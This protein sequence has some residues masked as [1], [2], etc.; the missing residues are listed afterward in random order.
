[1]QFNTQYNA[2]TDFSMLQKL[3]QLTISL[4]AESSLE[5][6]YWVWRSY[7]CAMAT[8]FIGGETQ[9]NTMQ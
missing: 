9:Y 2:F 1:M 4:L 5:A 8:L 7:Y 3:H 6:D